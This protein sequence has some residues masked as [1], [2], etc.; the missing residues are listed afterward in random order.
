MQLV[1]TCEQAIIL[2]AF[3]DRLRIR[4]YSH[5]YQVR[6]KYVTDALAAISKTFNVVGKQS[7]IQ[8][9]EGE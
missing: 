5:V 2:T 7:P 8:Q 1:H 3:L 9:T 6:V 4:F